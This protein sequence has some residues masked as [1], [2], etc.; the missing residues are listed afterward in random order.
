[1]N[2]PPNCPICRSSLLNDY[3]S[4]TLPGMKRRIEYLQKTCASSTSH[5]LIFNSASHNDNL[6]EEI[7]LHFPEKSDI[8]VVSWSFSEGVTQI[9]KSNQYRYLPLWEPDFSNFPKLLSKIRK[10]LIFS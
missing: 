6:L 3:K 2:I 4:M 1:M 9:I 7:V 10:Y 5:R 8:T